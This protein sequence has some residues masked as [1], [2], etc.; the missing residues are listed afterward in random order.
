MGAGN[1]LCP[2][3]DVLDHILSL[4][5]KNAPN[6]HAGKTGFVIIYFLFLSEQIKILLKAIY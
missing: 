2:Y 1:P 3:L 5:G 6:S 4:L